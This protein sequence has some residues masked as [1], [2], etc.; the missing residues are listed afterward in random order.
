MSR[1]A[2]GNTLPEMRTGISVLGASHRLIDSVTEYNEY[3]EDKEMVHLKGHSNL[4]DMNA[5]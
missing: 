3:V 4:T 5:I 1:R 2:F